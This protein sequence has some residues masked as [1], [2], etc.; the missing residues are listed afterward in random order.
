MPDA[1]RHDLQGKRA[2]IEADDV[3]SQPAERQIEVVAHKVRTREFVGT[4]EALFV[5]HPVAIL[6]PGYQRG[7]R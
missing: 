5:W 6:V 1:R 2:G 3:T 7:R 4:A